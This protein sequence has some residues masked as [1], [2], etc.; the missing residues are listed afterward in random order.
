MMRVLMLIGVAAVSLAGCK[1][2]SSEA[3]PPVPVYSPSVQSRTA[4]EL[5]ALPV[6]SCLELLVADYAVMRAQLRS[7]QFVA[8]AGCGDVE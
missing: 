2:V 6:G 7:L 1:T 8:D 5:D 3:L 4:I